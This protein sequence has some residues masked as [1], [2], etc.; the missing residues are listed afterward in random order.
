MKTPFCFFYVLKIVQKNYFVEKTVQPRS[1]PTLSRILYL[2]YVFK[3]KKKEK[4]IF[5]LL[6]NKENT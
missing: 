5:L 4:R 1:K 6:T 3:I 2:R